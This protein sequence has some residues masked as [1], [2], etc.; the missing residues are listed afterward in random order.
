MPNGEVQEEVEVGIE[1]VYTEMGVTEETL[2]G[3]LELLDWKEETWDRLVTRELP[4]ND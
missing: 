1:E 2:F 4:E 3:K